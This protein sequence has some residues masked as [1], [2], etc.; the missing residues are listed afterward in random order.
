MKILP[1][2]PAGPQIQTLLSTLNCRGAKNMK[3]C[4]SFECSALLN[5]SLLTSIVKFNFCPLNC[6]VCSQNFLTLFFDL[7]FQC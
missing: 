1:L 3:V 7:Y 6:P 2:T 4:L 5:I